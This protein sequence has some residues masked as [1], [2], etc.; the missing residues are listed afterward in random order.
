MIINYCINLNIKTFG[1]EDSLDFGLE[2]L[3]MLQLYENEM[4]YFE[5]Y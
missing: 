3:L 4:K 1:E 2:S 5:K